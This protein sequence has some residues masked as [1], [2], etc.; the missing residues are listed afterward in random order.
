MLPSRFWNR[1][2]LDGGFQGNAWGERGH[3][4]LLYCHTSYATAHTHQIHLWKEEDDGNDYRRGRGK[5]IARQ[6][7]TDGNL[8]GGGGAGSPVAFLHIALISLRSVR[9]HTTSLLIGI[10]ALQ[11][12]DGGGGGGEG[13]KKIQLAN[14]LLFLGT[15][16]QIGPTEARRR[17]GAAS[18]PHWCL[19]RAN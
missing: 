8:Q 9:T 13:N 2:N 4:A 6:Y 15:K 17:M 3:F 1:C 7:L 10:F 18:S 11:R 5:K 12:R 19:L 16:N 14:C